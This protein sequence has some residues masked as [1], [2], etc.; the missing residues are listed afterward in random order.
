MP[1]FFF[2][3]SGAPSYAGEPY[4]HV[5]MLPDMEDEYDPEK[6]PFSVFVMRYVGSSTLGW[7]YCGEYV[8]FNDLRGTTAASNVSQTSKAFIISDIKKSLQRD[9]GYWHEGIKYKRAH[10]M[11]EC[12]RDPSPPGP[13]RLIRFINNDPEPDDEGEERK[14][15]IEK[16]DKER[17]TNAAKARALGLDNENL[18]AIEFAKRLVHYDDFYGSYAIQF[19]R[20]DDDMYDFVKDGMTTKNKHNKKRA[21]NEPCAKASDWYNIMDQQTSA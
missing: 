9:N 20:Y 4:G 13:T 3:Y 12:A 2:P 11:E 10:I 17:A 6:C 14:E 1:L 7:E 15:R 8:L 21:A 5:T 19:V 18:S 16:E